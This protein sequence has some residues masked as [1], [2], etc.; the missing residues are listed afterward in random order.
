MNCKRTGRHLW[1]HWTIALIETTF[2][3]KYIQ[4]FYDFDQHEFQL[5]LKV[6]VRNAATYIADK[7]HGK[8]KPFEIKFHG[9]NEIKHDE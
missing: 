4:T 9:L 8:G 2:L 7:L 1:S 5:D 3:L 6:I